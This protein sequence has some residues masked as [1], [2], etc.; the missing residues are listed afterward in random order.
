MIFEEI[1]ILAAIGSVGAL[2]AFSVAGML[3]V[4]WETTLKPV[5]DWFKSI[6]S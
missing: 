2:W 5:S 4:I 1:M 6:R 3:G